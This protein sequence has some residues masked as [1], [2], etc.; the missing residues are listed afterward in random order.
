MDNF[1]RE[2]DASL[3]FPLCRGRKKNISLSLFIIFLGSINFLQWSVNFIQIIT[4]CVVFMPKESI[5]RA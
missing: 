5:A 4:T 3:L 1:W 2:F